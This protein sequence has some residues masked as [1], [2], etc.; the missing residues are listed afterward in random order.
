MRALKLASVRSQLDELL[1]CTILYNL[2]YTNSIVLTAIVAGAR[3]Y[4]AVSRCP[5]QQLLRRWMRSCCVQSC[6][7][8]NLAAFID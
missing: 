3:C 6:C 5:G 4:P 8:R 2:Q 7:R 1:L